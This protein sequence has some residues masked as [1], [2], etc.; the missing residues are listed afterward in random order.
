[1]K[2][3]IQRML[4]KFLGYERYLWVFTLYKLKVLKN[5][6]SEKDF[7]HFVGLLPKDAMVLDIGANLGL[8]TYYLS[9]AAK[10]VHAFEPI[11]SNANN[12]QKLLIHKNLSNV[13]VHRCALG[14]QSGELEL[15]LPEVDGVI[16]QGLSHVKADK[17]TEFNEGVSVK[18]EV[19]TLD[20][21][22]RSE[23][24]KKIDG[25]KIDVE[26]FEYEVFKGALATLKED[27]PLVY[28]EL[29]DNQNRFDCFKL[30][31]ELNYGI[32]ELIGEKLVEL[33]GDQ[34]HGQN[35]FFIPQAN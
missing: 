4:Q 29:W 2:S 26:N 3:F 17:M 13:K 8:M 33:K 24:N 11:P 32:Y 14:D 35:F 20:D 18:A 30:F 7:F 25:I 27:K 34:S 16:K 19:H 23:L 21:L 1:M 22:K 28:C 12:L 31:K 6:P 15:I 10:E 5:D 9:K